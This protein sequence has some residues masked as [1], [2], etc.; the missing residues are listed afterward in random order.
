MKNFVILAALS[1]VIYAAGV[2]AQPRV[3]PTV[4]PKPT[5]LSAST[6]A[7]NGSFM[8]NLYKNTSLGFEIKVPDGWRIM[9]DDTNRATLDVGK[10]IIKANKSKGA[11][12]S[13]DRSISNTA[14]LFQATPMNEDNTQATGIFA[15]GTETSTG[16]H[17][18]ATYVEMN[19]DLILTANPG[20]K[21]IKKTYQKMAGGVAFQAVDIEKPAQL[22]GYTQTLM[23]TQRKGVMFFFV[24]TYPDDTS[25]D[26][27]EG[28]FKTLTF[29]K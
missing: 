19:K 5:P 7:E 8:G 12:T 23:V 10:E 27:L 2:S 18:A 6:I 4:K 24:L 16:A 14:V 9:S 28:A 21:V 20:A 25:R 3:K 13:L 1:L 22:G 15:C 26:N 17:T 11:K 29:N